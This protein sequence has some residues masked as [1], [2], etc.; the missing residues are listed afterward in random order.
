MR[1]Q[2]RG[3]LLGGIALLASGCGPG[4][5]D[6]AVA[7]RLEDITDD[8]ATVAARAAG[9][10]ATALVAQEAAAAAAE[11]RRLL[12]MF[13]ASWCPWCRRLNATFTDPAVAPLLDAH[14]RILHLRVEERAP[15]MAALGLSEADALYRGWAGGDP[16]GLPFL[17]AL[18]GAA[19]VV[20]T[21]IQPA[22]GGN[23]GFPVSDGELAGFDAMLAAA[24]PAMPAAERGV[25]RA[26]CERIYS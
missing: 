5:S 1:L 15:A 6:T 23:F 9:L 25:I 22:A 10:S 13:F 21:S 12:V 16:P 18:D 2:R 26:A 4:G 11:D 20:T 17:A 8:P 14:V 3:V 7:P 19:E 24:A